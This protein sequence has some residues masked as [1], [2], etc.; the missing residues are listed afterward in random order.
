ME[1]SISESEIVTMHQLSELTLSITNRI[2]QLRNYER[3]LVASYN[4]VGLSFEYGNEDNFET[5]RIDILI[6]LNADSNPDPL[7]TAWNV[8]VKIAREEIEK[9]I[10][11]KYS[12]LTDIKGHYKKM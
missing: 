5:P 4:R 2:S 6:H 8:F 3:E 10:Q 9:E 11:E 7:K 12:L 1:K